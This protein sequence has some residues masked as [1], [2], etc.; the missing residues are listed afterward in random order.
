MI[1]QLPSLV[2]SMVAALLMAACGGGQRQTASDAGTSAA[3]GADGAG[4][5]AGTSTTMTGGSAAQGGTAGATT[6]EPAPAV[7]PPVT[8]QPPAGSIPVPTAVDS[9]T[10]T[11][12]IT[13]LSPASGPESGGNMVVISG[14]N[15]DAAQVLFGSQ[16]AKFAEPPT[17]TMVAVIVPKQNPGTVTVVVTNKD[18]RYAVQNGG[19][20]YT[21]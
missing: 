14:S 13:A 15:F 8:N 6:P 4:S 12:T 11:P 16:L 3:P 17:A 20:T 5:A 2:A 21:R 9:S 19:Y 1:R 10:G 18:G 7:A